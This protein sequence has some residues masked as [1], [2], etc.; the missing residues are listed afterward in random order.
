M[1]TIQV[2][3][4]SYTTNSVHILDKVSLMAEEGEITALLGHNGSGKSTL[5]DLLCGIIKSKEGTISIYDS[6]FSK[7]KN[8]I[9]V[10]WDN[11]VLFPMLKVKEIIRFCKSIYQLKNVPE[12]YYHM[13]EL[14]KIKDRFYYQLSKG[15]KKRV[16][17]Y[18]AVIH[19]PSLLILDEPTSDLDPIVREKIW[20]NI[21]KDNSRSILFTTHLWDEAEKYADKVYFIY[22]GKILQAPSSP[23]K[24]IENCKYQQKIILPKKYMGKVSLKEKIGNKLIEDDDNYNIL[25]NGNMDETIN[26]ISQYSSNFSVLPIEL[27]DVYQ[28]FINQ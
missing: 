3:D 9:G 28:I 8:K 12:D 10:L 4:V 27:K 20:N 11:P 18:V 21:F 24:Y 13:L 17:I 5:I 1:K 16:A 22:K 6:N 2:S 19:Q 25:V 15:E 23:N 26:K 7:E 14:D